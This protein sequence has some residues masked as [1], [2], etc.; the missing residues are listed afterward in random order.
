MQN[1][2]NNRLESVLFEGV[3]ILN[4]SGNGIDLATSHFG[5]H[6]TASPLAMSDFTFRDLL[7]DGGQMG[8]IY[9]DDRLSIGTVVIE[10]AT[11][12]GTMQA[13]VMLELTAAASHHVSLKDVLIEGVAT[14]FTGNASTSLP[15]SRAPLVLG[16]PEYGV[17]ALKYQVIDCSSV[18]HA[19]AISH[20]SVSPLTHPRSCRSAGC[21]STT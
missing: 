20:V 2:H 1:D 14:N 7:I 5:E 4:N 3:R 8:G 16:D 18:S 17:I 13:A 6:P 21:H 11:I 15:G 12:R 19:S 9:W 10:R